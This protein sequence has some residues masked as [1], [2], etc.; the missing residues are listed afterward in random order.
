MINL[1]Y[2][3]GIGFIN[4]VVFV[5]FVINIFIK[6]GNRGYRLYMHLLFWLVFNGIIFFGYVLPELQKITVTF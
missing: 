5:S 4:F 6:K 1:F 3:Y 2:A